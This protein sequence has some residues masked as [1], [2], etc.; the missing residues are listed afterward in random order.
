M[1]DG[2]NGTPDLRDKFVI[3]AG[4]SFVVGDTGGSATHTH[5]IFG[6][7]HVHTVGSGAAISSAAGLS[8]ITDVAGVTGTT[9]PASMAPP[10]YSLA[11]IMRL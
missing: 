3:G 9:D 5:P 1:C 11:Y 4:S 8:S 2:S 7:G 6:F 10:W